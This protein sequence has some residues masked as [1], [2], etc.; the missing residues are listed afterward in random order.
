MPVIR[1][2]ER[3]LSVPVPDPLIRS[4]QDAARMRKMRL[5]EAVIE[6]M[7]LWVV[8]VP[9]IDDLDATRQDRRRERL[10]D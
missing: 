9:F 5:R 2:N 3:V 7:Q 6:A 1:G 10:T 8:T 4:V